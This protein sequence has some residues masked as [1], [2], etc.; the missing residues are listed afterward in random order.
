MTDKFLSSIIDPTQSISFDPSALLTTSTINALHFPDLTTSGISDSGAPPRTTSLN[1]EGVGMCE[2]MTESYC[3]THG[4]D[5]GILINTHVDSSSMTTSFIKNHNKKDLAAQKKRRSR[6]AQ[7][8]AATDGFSLD[9]IE[10]VQINDEQ[11]EADDAWCVRPSHSIFV[12]PSFSLGFSKYQVEIR[13]NLRM[14]IFSLGFTKNSKKT[15]SMQINIVCYVNSMICH[16]VRRMKTC[17]SYRNQ[18]LFSARTI[19][20]ISCHNFPANQRSDSVKRSSTEQ[21]VNPGILSLELPP[22]IDLMENALYLT[23]CFTTLPLTSKTTF[24]SSTLSL[25]SIEKENDRF[26]FFL[27]DSLDDEN[28]NDDDEKHFIRTIVDERRYIEQLT[29]RCSSLDS[30]DCRKTIGMEFLRF[31]FHQ[32][33]E[34]CCE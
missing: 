17:F 18:S 19:R 27:Y 9:K 14:K 30:L 16:T 1:L 6:K 21:Q 8:D 33:V 11:L 7:F 22:A 25:D 3:S 2:S 20:S 4:Q 12:I 5:D 23:E 10:T 29:R 34:I 15:I 28:N 32:H 24:V 13:K 31:S 26:D